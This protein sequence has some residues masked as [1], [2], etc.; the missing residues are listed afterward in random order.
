ME[1]ILDKGF[2]KTGCCAAT[3]AGKSGQSLTQE[4]FLN[5]LNLYISG[6]IEKLE[7]GAIH[8]FERK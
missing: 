3:T 2:D 7:K 5:N 4:V 6:T 8:A 1:S